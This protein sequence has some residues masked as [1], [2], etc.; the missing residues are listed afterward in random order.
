FLHLPYFRARIQ[1]TRRAD[2]FRFLSRRIHQGAQPAEFDCAWTTGR[3]ITA[4]RRGDLAAFLTERRQTF[5]VHR[6]RV[7][8]CQVE[9]EPWPLREVKLT[10]L[11]STLFPAAGVPE[12]AGEPLAYHADQ[13]AVE[14]C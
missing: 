10:H 12:P 4:S 13:L 9:H 8:V 11:R 5:T 14:M 1:Q 3:P 2:T 6:G 7:Y